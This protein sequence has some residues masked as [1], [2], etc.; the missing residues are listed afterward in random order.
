MGYTHTTEFLLFSQQVISNSFA[1]P[2][3]VVHQS[4]LS[5]G[6]P[7]KEYWSGLP[8]PLPGDLSDQGS[9][10]CLL[11]WQADYLKLLSHQGI[12]I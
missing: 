2:W 6:F 12:T 9:N 10:S 7:R 4:S 1:A 5:V 3:T 11:H 8:S